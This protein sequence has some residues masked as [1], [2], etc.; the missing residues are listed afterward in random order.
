MIADEGATN[1]PRFQDHS[2]RAGGRE[3]ATGADGAVERDL[4]VVIVGSHT[5]E[6]VRT[7]I[8]QGVICE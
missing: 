8:Y 4:T 6:S 2:L 3:T 5:K 7:C 1:H